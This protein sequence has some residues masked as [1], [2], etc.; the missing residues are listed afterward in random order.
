MNSLQKIQELYYLLLVTKKEMRRTK[1]NMADL[2]RIAL[3]ELAWMSEDE[4]EYHEWR[5]QHGY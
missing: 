2:I 4:A 5:N 3:R 1:T